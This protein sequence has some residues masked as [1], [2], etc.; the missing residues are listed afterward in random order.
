MRTVQKLADDYIAAWNERD[1]V[2]RRALIA[3][4]WIAS[5]KYVDPLMSG[6][7]TDE[8]DGLI[9]MVQERFPDYH[10][11]LL[12]AADGHGPVARF[13]WGLG[14]DGGVSVIKGTDFVH[15][16]GDHIASVTGFLDEAPAPR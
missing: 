14:P 9:A 12:G 1:A 3:A 11:Y 15:R 6:A 4:T 13:S 5:A 16:D 2:R 7:G 8:I 10:F